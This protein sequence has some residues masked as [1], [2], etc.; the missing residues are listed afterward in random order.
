MLSV[1]QR[2]EPAQGVI[3]TL[4]KTM[5]VAKDPKGL[6]CQLAPLTHKIKFS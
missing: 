2:K 1:M 6:L 5:L 3:V 4:L